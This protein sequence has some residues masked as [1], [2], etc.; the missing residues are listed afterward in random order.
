MIAIRCKRECLHEVPDE[1]V[2]QDERALVVTGV[3]NRFEKRRRLG[4][5][6]DRLRDGVGDVQAPAVEDVAFIGRQDR[7]R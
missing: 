5:G 7:D 1:F 2:R 6:A 4:I 3:R